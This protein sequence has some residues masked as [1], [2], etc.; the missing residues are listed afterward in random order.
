MLFNSL[1]YAIFLLCVFLLYWILPY[2]LRW[3]LLLISSYYFYMSWNPKYV[4]L[5]SITTLV[6]Y[7]CARLIEKTEKTVYKRL[8][9]IGTLVVSLGILYLFKY[10]NFSMDLIERFIHITASRYSFLLPVG[11]SFYTFQ[12]L[13]YVID[14]YRGEIEA[15]K[16]L[17]VY[18]TFVSFFP[19]LVAGPIERTANL[20]P[21]INSEK[22][23]NYESAKYGVRLILWGLY[24]KM[25]IADN[26]AV[27]VDQVYGNVNSYEGCSLT[28]AALFFSIQIYCDF[29][30]YSD[31]ARGSAK[32]LNIELMEN[33]KSPYFSASI[34]EFWSRW[35]ISLSTWFRDYVYIPLGGNRVSKGRNIINYMITFW[36][37]GLWHGANLT[38]V[39]WG[40]IHGTGQVYEKAFS[41]GKQE[42]RDVYW[43][44]RVIC[45]FFFVSVAWIFFRANDI[46]EALYVLRHSLTGLSNIRVYFIDGVNTLG[47]TE[48]VA[49]KI[50]LFYLAPLFIYDFISLKVDVCDWIGKRNI[51]IRYTYIGAIIMAILTMG[52]V[53]KSTFVYFQF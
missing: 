42:K 25:V 17:G 49:K 26:I 10:Y 48:A 18:A 21:Q 8:C 38:F 51:I 30:G 24:K 40:G 3:V 19:Q 53:G 35:H 27:W 29:S 47:I 52:Y 12:T 7:I 44:I 43:I 5:I 22:K 36:V 41:V 14:V 1:E 39:M 33:F 28:L 45:V 15:E 6:S 16:N 9:L 46:N 31:I 32:L 11:I 4:V 2:K 37:S 50:L 13:S 20:M 23:F 34:K